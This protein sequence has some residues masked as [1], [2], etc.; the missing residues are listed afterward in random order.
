MI[1]STRGRM[2]TATLVAVMLATAAVFY[3][4]AMSGG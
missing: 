1:P 3:Q 2:S 4:A